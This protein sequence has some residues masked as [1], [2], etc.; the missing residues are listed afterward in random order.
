MSTNV[1]E[2]WVQWWCCAWRDAHPEWRAR[3]ID[4]SGLP[5]AICE[6]LAIQR[7]DVFLKF[8]GVVF[9]QPPEPESHTL[10]WL[11]LDDSQSQLALSLVGRICSPEH[12]DSSVND[13]YTPWCRSVAKA[14]RPGLWLDSKS[15]DPRLLLGVWLGV[16]YWSRVRLYWSP[17]AVEESPLKVIAANTMACSRLQTLWPAVFWQVTEGMEMQHAG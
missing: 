17:N 5:P 13:E 7:V 12:P 1:S 16:S 14:L 11:S 6:T 8:A 9:L 15:L 10:K 2:R 3:F 4:Q